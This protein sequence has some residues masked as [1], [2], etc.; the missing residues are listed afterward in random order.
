MVMFS[1]NARKINN[2]CE[3]DSQNVQGGNFANSIKSI[4]NVTKEKNGLIFVL[5]EE[6]IARDK[7][8]ILAQQLP[9]VI[10]GK[11]LYPTLFLHEK[12][13]NEF[14]NSIKCYQESLDVNK[15]DSTDEV[16]AQA[17][18][19]AAREQVNL[20]MGDVDL[21]SFRKIYITGHGSVGLDYILSGD[22]K[23]T[24]KEIVDCLENNKILDN[25]NDLRFTCCDSADRRKL[26]NLSKESISVSN[27]SS[28]FFEGLFFGKSESFIEKISSEIWGRGYTDIRVSGYHGKGVFYTGDLPTSHLRSSTIPA[29]DAVKRKNVRVTLVS[30]LD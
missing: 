2:I 23:I 21:K 5:G 26:D 12:A 14:K 29:T 19:L 18:F 27:R 22:S 13:K 10:R 15:C 16:V 1:V 8:N 9:R 6:N 4:R 17:L 25:I 30:E 3:I 11:S 7:M 20:S 24:V 28:G